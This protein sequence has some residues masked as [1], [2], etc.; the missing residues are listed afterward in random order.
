MLKLKEL[1]ENLGLSQAAVARK[2]GISRQLYGFYESGDRDPSTDMLRKLADFF[3][4]SVDDLL[5]REVKLRKA[6]K[7]KESGIGTKKVQIVGS[8]KCGPDGLAYEEFGDY[9]YISPKYHGDYIALSCRGDSMIDSGIEEG[10]I[11]VVRLQPEVENG[12]LAVVILNGDEGTLKRV[13]KCRNGIVLEPAN[14]RYEP[15]IVAGA[16]L[17]N[18]RIVGK[19]V[20]VRKSL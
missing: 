12:E 5:G 18:F 13:R 1:R 17:E 6:V 4:I 10:D 14:P 2:L 3:D 8:V 11:V 7:L 16:D 20:E 9:I 19:A 15:I